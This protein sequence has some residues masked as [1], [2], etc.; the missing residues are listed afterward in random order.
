MDYDRSTAV[1]FF[2]FNRPQLTAEVFERIRS[3]RPKR[4]MVIADGP[5]SAKPEDLQLCSA[6]REIVSSAD[7]PCEL[8]TNFS[9]QN[10]GVRKRISS[11]L[12]WVF[13][14]CPEAI[15]LEDDCLPSA[16]FFS[17]CSEMLN[18]Y[19]QDTRI[20]HISGDNFQDGSRR[21]D[22]S[23]FFSRYAHS[24][25]WATWS[26]AWRHYDEKLSLWP[27]ARDERWLDSIFDDSRETKYWET[28]LEDV[29]CERTNTWDYQWLF[30]CWCQSGLAI[31]PNVNLVSNVGMGP[32]ATHFQAGH[33]TLGI[34]AQEMTEC[35]HPTTVIRDQEADRFTFQ[36]R[37]AG[38]EALAS[39]K[40]LPNLRNRLAL[41]SRVRRLLR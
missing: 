11:G 9:E 22:G 17:F 32:D 21:G 1:A 15:I 25:G 2:I 23:Y 26:R 18:Y 10:L 7:W 19:R 12:D 13:Q 29:Y 37:I 36:E 5:R 34:P 41:R 14:Q 6:T 24:W 4:L 16:S 8:L 30:T 27:R 3:V 20:M 35:I 33:V 38:K 31:L 39:E 28:I 40:W